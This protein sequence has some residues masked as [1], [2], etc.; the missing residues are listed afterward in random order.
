MR[1]CSFFFLLFFSCNSFALES[2]RY[3][4]DGTAKIV[5]PSGLVIR[6]MKDKTEGMDEYCLFHQRSVDDGRV[7]FISK[8]GSE[9]EDCYTAFD[10]SR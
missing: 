9:Y 2:T 8:D 10:R 7:F 6:K 1:L 5:L 4:P 3:I